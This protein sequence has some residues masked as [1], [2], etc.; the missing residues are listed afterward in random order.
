MTGTDLASLSV[1]LRSLIAA[2][3]VGAAFL[4]AAPSALGDPV[5]AA[6]GDIACDPSSPG[7]NGGAGVDDE[8]H[9]Q[10]TSDLLLS[11]APDRVLSLGDNQYSDGAEDKYKLSYDSTWG[12]L[13]DITSPTPGNHEYHTAGA[14]GYFG[15]FQSAAGD[16][17]KGYYS[18]DLGTWHVVVLN[19]NCSDVGGCE[20]GSAQDQWLRADLASHPT[21]CTLAYWHHPRFSSGPHG[22]NMAVLPFWQSLYEAGADVVLNGHDH[23]Y[24]RFA[25]QAPDG[26]PDLARGI[27]EFVVGTGG[28]N[29]YVLTNPVSTSEVFNGDTFGVLE[30][31]LHP[32]GYEWRFVPEAGQTFTDS[33]SGTCHWTPVN[34]ARPNL[35]GVAQD[36]QTLTADTGTWSAM[37]AADYRYQWRRCDETGVVCAGIVGATQSTYRLG[38]EDVGSR[39][40]VRVYASNAVGAAYARSDATDVV[41]G[42]PP[43]NVDPPA[44]A[45]VARDGE[46]LTADTG[47]W[48]G[49]PT[50][51][52]AYS[53]RRC[54]L[55]GV[56]CGGIAEANQP[57]YQLTPDDVGSRIR[58]RVYAGNAF[59]NAYASSEATQTVAGAPPV[60]TVA[61]QVSGVMRDGETLTADPGSWTG[62]PPL[63]YTYSWRRCDGT[64]SMCW[65]I[66]G[67]TQQAYALTPDDV[68]FRIRVRVYATNP[69]GSVY[70]RS[71]A[72]DVVAAESPLSTVA[73][74]VSSSMLEARG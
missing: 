19:S 35:S 59:G 50:L 27:R 65:G 1:R 57:S 10:A 3:A 71:A 66:A 48:T 6:A 4:A 70:A 74:Q 49:T 53:W 11:L 26:T 23:D 47:S 64:G 25:L 44:V 7:Y 34:T 63:S 33:G 21:S 2:T 58:V 68:G 31:T 16:P 39:I 15:Y 73:P 13:K 32:T 18:Y 56:V 45:G 12:R 46:T 55:T 22:D 42:A 62:T 54:D 69:F 40:R 5:V 67:A 38:P 61:P 17:A 9:Q 37:P 24:E 60:N 43:V 14:A 8:C 52:Y 72:G 29:H 28:R 36:G 20:A 41:A 30:L 51:S